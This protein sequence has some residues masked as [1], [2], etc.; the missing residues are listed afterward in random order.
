M[1]TILYKENAVPAIIK[2]LLFYG[3]VI[4][5]IV[6][7]SGKS[8]LAQS[9]VTATNQVQ[10]VNAIN[11]ANAGTVTEII[12]DASTTG[13]VLSLNNT[14][15]PQAGLNG[16]DYLIRSKDGSVMTLKGTGTDH[17]LFSILTGTTTGTV[18]FENLAFTDGI[19]YVAVPDSSDEDFGRGCGGAFSLPDSGVDLIFKGTTI[20]SNNSTIMT[21]GNHYNGGAIYGRAGTKVTYT[22]DGDIVFNDNR[23]QSYGGAISNGAN[24]KTGGDQWFLGTGN[25][26]FLNNQA[27]GI[28]TNPGVGGAIY[29][30]GNM[31]FDRVG[32]ILFQGNRAGMGGAIQNERNIYFSGVGKIQFINN[33][34]VNAAST[35]G[36]AIGFQ[37]GLPGSCELVFNGTGDV[38]FIGNTTDQFGGAIYIQQSS[39]TNSPLT[40][41]FEQDGDLLFQGNRTR[42]SS[43]GGGGAVSNIAGTYNFRNRGNILFEDNATATE[44]GGISNWSKT[45][46]SNAGTVTFRGN[47]A[48]DTGG[49]VH[50]TG[51]IDFSG[52]NDLLFDSNLSGT[53]GG[54]Y[55]GSGSN[56]SLTLNPLGHAAVTFRGNRQY[57][58]DFSDLNSGTPNAMN[59]S[60]GSK[61]NLTPEKDAAI[62]FYDPIAS[63]NSVVAAGKI[64]HNGDGV[65]RLWGS[66][67]YYGD[68]DIQKGRFQLIE[69]ARY[70]EWDLNAANYGHHMWVRDGATL[71]LSIDPHDVMNPYWHGTIGARHFE[72]EEGAKLYVSG[73]SALPAGVAMT[74]EDV[75]DHCETLTVPDSMHVRNGLIE[76]LLLDDGQM[77]GDL[78][79]KYVNDIGNDTCG[80]ELLYAN[81]LR[82]DPNLDVE[83]RGIFDDLYNYGPDPDTVEFLAVLGGSR[84]LDSVDAARVRGEMF[85]KAM[86]DRM[87]YDDSLASQLW[88]CSP[89]YRPQVAQRDLMMRPGRQ[90]VRRES[91][92]GTFSQNWTSQSRKCGD[93]NYRY[94]PFAFTV[95]REKQVGY[96]TLGY[97]G[98][99]AH[100][101]VRSGRM[102]WT[103]TRTDGVSLGAY[104]GYYKYRSYLKGNMQLGLG[105]N[106]ENTWY[107]KTGDRNK[108]SYIN[109]IFGTG[110][111]WGRVLCLGC[112]TNPLEVTPHL[113][114]DY[115]LIGQESFRESGTNYTR[116][117]GSICHN[118][119]EIPFGLRISKSYQVEG[120]IFHCSRL[121]LM[122]DLI[123][124]RSVADNAAVTDVNL[125][126]RPQTVWH[127]RS[128]DIGRDIFK[129]S[130]G[131]AGRFA[132]K[133]DV[134]LSYDLESRLRYNS[135]QF[136]A[137]LTWQR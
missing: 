129:M 21:T 17:S 58:S 2:I 59:L 136:N 90:Q 45:I 40:M 73:I 33:E 98:Q 86:M 71:G 10:L 43:F 121:R 69:N 109:G 55:N 64:I 104:A 70:G 61:V 126:S 133:F 27:T 115:Y 28:S 135:Q 75:I 117:F 35:G 54:A 105:W 80:Y 6:L 93:Y 87:A 88:G 19:S 44:G 72:G 37:P 52:S 106:S 102:S 127:G 36:G 81:E 32:D 123:Y 97:T 47:T 108:A 134:S 77:H 94:R 50:N 130:A 9:P 89:G 46:F 4:F 95:G 120:G 91:F 122:V 57:V 128:D 1:P 118:V 13:D 18:T 113:G 107:A 116:R 49:A 111:E 30:Q 137:A 11:A 68:T 16:K 83:L 25:V 24:A 23:A 100:G 12:I 110:L 82:L 14:S 99:Y 66:S 96:W 39:Y 132:N 63:A 62:Y 60:G 3:I 79:I 84:A 131:L 103:N 8:L 51:I 22:G 92:W 15:L 38:E 41:T 67:E 114:A 112:K 119:A 48:L 124:A 7:M 101:D 34:A 74:Y 26:S 42:S 125:L 56:S 31:T 29:N 20:F 5:G 65:T 53:T 85:G 76:A 78:V